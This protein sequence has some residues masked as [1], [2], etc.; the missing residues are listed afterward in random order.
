M[1]RASRLLPLLLLALT[2]SATPAS[3]ASTRIIVR[4]SGGL[5]RLKTICLLLGC[6]V[7]YG[8][9]DPNGQVFLI[10]TT[11]SLLSPL[12]FLNAL[13]LQL[14]VIDVELDVKGSIQSGATSAPAALSDTTPVNYYGATVWH[15][16]VNQP[17]TQ[18][19]RLADT[20]AT[21]GVDG[22]GTGHRCGLGHSPIVLRSPRADI[23]STG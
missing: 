11:T 15:G 10:T 14:G 17:A 9:G 19:I 22:S 7:D 13:Q 4:V 16:Y 21:Y 2:L 5:L 20:Q 6:N 12:S 23:T 1:K 3:A 18:I 8:L